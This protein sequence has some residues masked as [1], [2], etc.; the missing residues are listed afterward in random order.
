MT[1]SSTRLTTDSRAR[2]AMSMIEMALGNPNPEQR[3]GLLADA[4]RQIAN[5][6]SSCLDECEEQRVSWTT[7]GVAVGMSRETVWRQ[8]NA[9][10]PIVAIKPTYTPRE[11]EMIDSIYAFETETNIWFG[12][13]NAFGPG[14]Y[15]TGAMP[16]RPNPAAGENKLSGQVLRVRIGPQPEAAVSVHAALVHMADGTPRRVRVTEEVMALLFNDKE[17]PLRRALMNAYNASGPLADV[18]PAVTAA[19]VKAANSMS[20]APLGSEFFDA[21]R[22]ALRTAEAKPSL[23]PKIRSAVVRLA[24]ALRDYEA[25]SQLSDN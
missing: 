16:F 13:E 18:D 22:T 21:V 14:K 11:E 5:A 24:Q 4:Q 12:P 23:D 17:M 2:N 6:L 3:A 19:M 15:A 8:H 1:S 25:W 20:A 9:R 7:I 10:R